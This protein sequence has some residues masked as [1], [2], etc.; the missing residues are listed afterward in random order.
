METLE[1]SSMRK[2]NRALYRSA[3]VA[4][5]AAVSLP[6]LALADTPVS[7]FTPGDY[8]I[9]RGGDSANPN[10]L[11]FNGEV[12][13]YIDE[14]SQAGYYVGTVVL[15]AMTLPGANVSSHEGNLNISP[16]GQ[17]I[18][19]AGYDPSTDGPG[20]TASPVGN[21]PHSTSG[22]QSAV[23]GEVNLST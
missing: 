10:G 3:V 17:W 8:L 22:T 23:I 2:C 18:A 20:T 6:V 7:Q 5:A 1:E 9:M 4:A 15:P 21:T 19:F 13:A 14:Y 16:N 12:N 11:N